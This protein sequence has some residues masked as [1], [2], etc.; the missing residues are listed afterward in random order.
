MEPQEKTPKKLSPIVDKLFQLK[1][2]FWRQGPDDPGLDADELTPSLETNVEQKFQNVFND[3]SVS[4][5]M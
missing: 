5:L 3:Y 2:S 1:S 4:R